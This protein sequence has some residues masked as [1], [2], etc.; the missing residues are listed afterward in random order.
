[1][2]SNH[3]RCIFE[4]DP[5]TKYI[6]EGVFARDEFL[7]T[8]FT[9]DIYMCVVNEQDSKYPGSHWLLVYQDGK[10]NYFIDSLGRDYTYYGLKLKR[11]VYQI[12]RRLQCLDSQLCGAYVIFFGIRLAREMNLDSIMDYF[13]WNCRLNDEFIY[14]Y[15]KEKL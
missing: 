5:Y 4:N 12:H 1:M 6:F 3:L 9:R 11:P 14:R 13:T 10:K 7:E 15:I 8:S 2:D